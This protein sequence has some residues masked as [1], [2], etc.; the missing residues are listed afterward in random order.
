MLSPAASWREKLRSCES[1]ARPSRLAWLRTAYA[2]VYRFLLARYGDAPVATESAPP[3]PLVDQTGEL[4]GKAARTLGEIRHALKDIAAA[5]PVAV[6]TPQPRDKEPWVTIAVVDKRLHLPGCLEWLVSHGIQTRVIRQGG[7]QV[8]CVRRDDTDRAF[9]LLEAEQQSP[10][11]GV[12]REPRSIQADHRLRRFHQHTA[13]LLLS[14]CTGSAVCVQLLYHLGYDLAMET[15]FLSA[16]GLGTAILTVFAVQLLR[17]S[18]NR[19]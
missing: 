3:R 15:T 17:I 6:A 16:A 11:H 14:F 9:A 8:V 13:L 1:D 12:Y 5:Q 18:R 4:E 7:R 10:T 19:R 2:R